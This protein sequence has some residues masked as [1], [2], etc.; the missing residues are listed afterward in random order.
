MLYIVTVASCIDVCNISRKVADRDD[1]L[2][3]ASANI[4]RIIE[5]KSNFLKLPFIKKL[6]MDGTEIKDLEPEAI[7]GGI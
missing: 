7:L 3:T 2:S 6:E 5:S 4:I 1:S